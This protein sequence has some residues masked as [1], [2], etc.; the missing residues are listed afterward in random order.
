MKDW[1]EDSTLLTVL[2]ERERRLHQ[3][4]VRRSPMAICRY[5]HPDFYE[6]GRSGQHYTRDDVLK[7]AC[8]EQAS[9]DIRIHAEG[10]YCLRLSAE[11]AL[12]FY[13]SANLRADGS[14]ERWARR[15]SL[16]WLTPHGWQL[17]FHQGAPIGPS[18]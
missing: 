14:C 11:S 7:S 15:C 8:E 17:R 9:L 3:P 16:W 10:D 18:P 4:T 6:V 2:A 12:L 13:R 1:P 5:L